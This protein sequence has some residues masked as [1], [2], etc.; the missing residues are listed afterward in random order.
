VR[1]ALTALGYG[2]EEIRDAMRQMTSATD[3]ETMLRD[4]LTLLGARRAG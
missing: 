4:A 1:E 2:A 3:S